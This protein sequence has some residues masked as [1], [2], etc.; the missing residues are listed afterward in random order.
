MCCH[1]IAS[2]NS[3]VGGIMKRHKPK[4]MKR[5]KKHTRQSTSKK[6]RLKRSVRLKY[7]APRTSAQYWKMP[8]QVRDTYDRAVHAL[9]Y[10]RSARVSRRKAA[11]KFNISPQVLARFAGKAL[12]RQSN[13]QYVA[14]PADKLLRLVVIP[15]PQGLQELATTDSHEATKVANYWIALNRYLTFGDASALRESKGKKI[16]SANGKKVSLLTELSELDRLASAGVLSFETI[17]AK[18]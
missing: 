10:M 9:T 3:F 6:L 16:T 1:V 14:R 11:Q 2:E 18:R 13:G 4:H 8:V 5:Q 17:Y 7:V 12:R 15:T